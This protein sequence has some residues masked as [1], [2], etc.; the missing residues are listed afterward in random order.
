VKFKFK[1]L[2]DKE[3]NSMVSL[4]YNSQFLEKIKTI[5]GHRWNSNENYCGFPNFRYSFATHLLERGV[6]FKYIQETL[7]HKSSKTKEVYTYIS[8]KDLRS[9]INHFDRLNLNQQK[10]VKI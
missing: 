6:D 9:F 5:N 2:R 7:A 10:D 3:N 1:I 8:T 4:P